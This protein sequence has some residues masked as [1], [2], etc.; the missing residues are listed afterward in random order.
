MNKT[1][2]FPVDSYNVI[3]KTILNDN[4]RLILYM[5]YQPLVGYKAISLYFTLWSNL[6][7]T[8]VMS[9]EF[10]HRYLMNI[11]GMKI[12]DIIEGRKKLEAIG[13]LKTLFKSGEINN[14]IYQLYSP[15][16]PKE[17]LT[18]PFLSILLYNNLGSKEYERLVNHYKLPDIN[19]KDFKDITI[20]FSDIFKT[21]TFI[22]KE[23][24]ESIR[25]RESNDINIKASLD[26]NYIINAFSDNLINKKTFDKKTEKLINS[27]SFLYDL[28][29]DE[30][31]S[32][33]KSS[34][35]EKGLIDK[36]KL[37]N[38][39][40]DLYKFE[41]NEIPHLIYREKS[42]TIDN[43]NNSNRSKMI[44]TFET[45]SPYKFLKGKYNDS[46]PTSRDKKLIESLLIDQELNPGV[47]NVLI[48][49]IL[50]INDNK[51]TKSYV[52]TIAGQW[53]RLNI[54]TV[55]E[56]MNQAEKDHK[57]YKNKGVKTYNN[58]QTDKTPEWFNKDLKS[59][60]LSE[61]EESKLKAML[62]EFS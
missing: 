3:N 22:M 47:V 4:D 49:Y 61:D 5:F 8:N 9:I 45:L 36:D 40:R 27:I 54:K 43:Q 23:K 10:N 17:I 24:E 39:A 25:N 42:A 19:T 13:L 20:S 52:E 57:A 15:L 51:L 12:E 58:K 55:I 37:S 46:E 33:I 6:D 32:L 56:A 16:S 31:I 44:Y 48:D 11:T 21:G 59:V 28:D 1:S 53:K 62:S 41:N 18:H 34:L 35:N 30:I 50:R 14:Y 29:N 26:F 2:L 7:H 60:E 38:N